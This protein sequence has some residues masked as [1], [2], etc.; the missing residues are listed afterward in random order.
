MANN[1]YLPSTAVILDPSARNRLC[2][3]TL[4]TYRSHRIIPS[5]LFTG[6]CGV[7]SIKIR[8]FETI[9]CLTRQTCGVFSIKIRIFLKNTVSHVC[10]FR[11]CIMVIG[12]GPRA[13][14]HVRATHVHARTHARTH[15]TVLKISFVF[16]I[17]IFNRHN[18][19]LR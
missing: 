2:A 13:H 15:V 19:E 10:L 18:H 12:V 17:T 7:C 5:G 14:T 4:Q 6:Q 1:V 8:I 11:L 3:H 9:L 16:K